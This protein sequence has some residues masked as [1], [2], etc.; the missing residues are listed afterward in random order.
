MGLRSWIAWRGADFIYGTLSELLWPRSSAAA[1]VVHEDELL[2][3]DMGD[4]LMLPAGGLEFGENFEQAAIREVFEET[5]YR[6][7][8]GEK[9]SEN[10]NSVGGVEMIFDA[11]LA[12]KEQEHSGSWG[13]PVWIP[14]DQLDE[15]N[16]RHNRDVKSILEGKQS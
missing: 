5:G 14:L 16:W 15:R 6:I 13:K 8:I 7:E 3:V 4:Y 9:L 11:D 2:A 12:D 1:I 10:V